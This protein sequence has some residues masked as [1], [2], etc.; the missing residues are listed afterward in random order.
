MPAGSSRDLFLHIK[1]EYVDEAHAA[2]Q[3]H[4]RGQADVRRVGDLI[5]DGYFGPPP[6]SLV[7]RHRV[8]DVVVL[9][10][11][12]ES[13]WWYEQDRFEQVFRG[14]HGGLSGDEMETLLLAQPYS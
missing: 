7:F 9:P 12:N 5:I 3:A 6:V 14:N 2:L 1:D 4:L 11:R 10:R 13:V 8:G